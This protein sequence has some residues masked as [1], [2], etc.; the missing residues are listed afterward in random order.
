MLSTVH[1]LLPLS[2]FTRRN[3]HTTIRR[4]AG[5]RLWGGRFTGET[6]PLMVQ[7]NNSIDFDKRWC[8]VD[9]QGSKAY[10]RATERVGILTAEEADQMIEGLDQVEQEWKDGV[11][12]I[13]PS[14][15]DIHTANERRL[16]E[17]IGAG[18]AGK[19]H[20]GRSRN[21]QVATD[22]RLW[23]RNEI[24]SLGTDLLALIEVA[25][26]RSEREIYIIMPGYT[27]LQ[28]AQPI[29]WSHW[30]L[31]HA[32]GFRRDYER[33]Q[34]LKKRVNVMPLGSGALAGHPF[35]IDRQRLAQDLEFDGVSTNSM[36]A[37]ADRD[38]VAEFLFWSSMTGIHL[39]RFAEDLILYSSKEFGFVQQSDAYST[40]SSLMPQKK[41]PDALELLRGKAGP[42]VGDL[43]SVLVSLKGIPTTYNKDL[44]EGWPPLYRA[45]DMS[46][47]CI[48]I[49]TGVL[50]T[51]D[52]VPE[53]M[54]ASLA[55]EM[56]ATDMA[57]YL[58]R[59]GVPFRETHHLAGECV[60]L[61]E[62]KG[63]TL[64]GLTKEELVN[65]H[66]C[67][68]DIDQPIPN[69]FSMESSVEA[70]TAIGGT[71]KSAV[72]QQCDEMKN[73]LIMSRYKG[74]ASMEKKYKQ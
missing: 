13:K 43:V 7:F 31:S 47:A 64:H 67:F 18:V 11:F 45:V 73:W 44:Q 15:E 70:R 26:E 2:G 23:L 29:R 57:D 34:D 24:E 51:L 49:A 50:S 28:P 5:D 39:S 21:D 60:A 53:Q 62:A 8:F 22:A 12:H 59:R 27:H 65:I 66:V 1:R 55:P 42:A 72:Q 61:A 35:G 40:G 71:S 19:L 36:D 69:E 17:L 16:S 38:Y 14:D 48:N 10:A 37:V 25:V 41:N 3:L 74:N 54:A 46:S 20:T 33:L 9:L 4:A 32:A 6:D 30:M 63:C 58:V 56:L 52:P 68:D